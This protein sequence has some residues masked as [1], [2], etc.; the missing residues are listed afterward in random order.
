MHWDTIS[1]NITL[2][3][4]SPTSKS[5]SLEEHLALPKYT[6]D[7]LPEGLPTL[8][9]ISHG[10]LPPLKPAPE[11]RFDVRT[12]PNPPK[13]LRDA[14]NGTSKRLQEWMQTYA[15]FFARRDEIKEE[16]EEAMTSITPA[17][18]KQEV[19]KFEPRHGDETNEDGG[20]SAGKNVE[21]EED[22]D[23]E[24]KN[25]SSS[26]QEILGDNNANSRDK[27]VTLRVGIYCAMGRHRSVAMVEALA[28]L[29]WPGW[30][31]EVLHRD[32]AKKKRGAGKKPGNLSR[33]SRGQLMPS[34]FGDDS[35]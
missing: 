19:L 3:M 11:L 20:I 22:E 33:G 6:Q 32:I 7:L 26:D 23:A 18:E 34:Q 5:S 14:H 10:H 29:S 1:P 31:V 2:H 15:K 4:D 16:I 30:R 17:Q 21:A 12:L 9:L 13:H 28:K 25:E 8:Y 27:K 35:E 24:A